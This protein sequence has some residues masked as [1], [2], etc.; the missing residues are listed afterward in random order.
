MWVTLNT[1]GMNDKDKIIVELR[2]EI[3]RLRKEIQLLKDE[4]A[5]LKK[6][7]QGLYMM[8]PGFY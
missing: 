7:A 1:G 5:R 4:I 6:D 3:I 8:L 2:K